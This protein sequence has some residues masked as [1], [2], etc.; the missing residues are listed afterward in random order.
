MTWQIIRPIVQHRVGA[1]IRWRII[2]APSGPPGP[3]GPA[4]GLPAI[5]LP[6]AVPLSAGSLCNVF[7]NDGVPALQ[8]ADATV[9]ARAHLFVQGA[10]EEGATAQ[11]VGPG[12]VIN[13]LS[14]LTPGQILY[15]GTAGHVT[16]TAPMTPGQI[17]Q[18]VGVALS[19]TS[20]FFLPGAAYAL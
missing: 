19:A 16:A 12:G 15:L 5:L 10:A 14:D 2:R 18:E 20:M 13:G 8:V 6:A 9:P 4:G 1:A 7:D 3:A 17:S 11:A